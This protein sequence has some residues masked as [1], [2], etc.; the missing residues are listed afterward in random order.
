MVH[1]THALALAELI[2]KINFLRVTHRN[3][4]IPRAKT[5]AISPL[6]MPDW[7][8]TFGKGLRYET[9]FYFSRSESCANELPEIPA[10]LQIYGRIDEEN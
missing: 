9:V 10:L 5:K 3:Y 1:A 6:I 4:E 2:E 8:S 7:T